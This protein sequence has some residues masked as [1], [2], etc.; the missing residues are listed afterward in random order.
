[1]KSNLYW[2]ALINAADTQIAKM[3]VMDQW[4]EEVR[5]DERDMVI[6]L[7]VKDIKNDESRV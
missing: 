4:E 2:L 1:M 5:Q 6:Q 7:L 3:E